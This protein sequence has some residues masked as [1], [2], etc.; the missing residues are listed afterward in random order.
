LSGI[1][2]NLPADALVEL[3][4]V[5]AKIA[6]QPVLYHPSADILSA[7]FNTRYCQNLTNIQFNGSLSQS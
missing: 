7:K 1:V 6:R 3:S 5:C 2:A 4:P